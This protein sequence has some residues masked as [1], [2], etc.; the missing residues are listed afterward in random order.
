M[1]NFP[2]QASSLDKLLR[3]AR[4][5]VDLNAAGVELT[6]AAFG[7]ALAR[8]GVY[9]FREAGD[10]DV[11]LAAEQLKAP[12]NQ[13]SRTAARD[14]RRTLRLL[15]VINDDGSPTPT[16]H[17]LISAQTDELRK[18]MWRSALL[19]MGLGEGIEESHPYRILLRLV[20]DNP[21]LE[22]RKLL[23]ALEAR[24]DTEVEYDRILDLANLPFEE[25]LAQT[26]I[27]NASAANAV[28]ILPSIA[29]QL[30][31]LVRTPDAHVYP[32]G[33]NEPRDI[34]EMTAVRVVRRTT[35]RQR[36]PLGEALNPDQ[37]APAPNFLPT[38]TIISDLTAGVELRKRRTEQHQELVRRFAATLNAAGFQ[39]YA[40]LFDCLA[41]R[42][43]RAVLIEAKTLDGSP[44]DERSQSEK[45]IGQLAGYRHFD[46][47]AGVD[48]E[49]VEQV[50]LFS[51]RPTE[52]IGQFLHELGITC[53]WPT[54]NGVWHTTGPDGADALYEL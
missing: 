51:A 1:K 32:A 33:T 28:K 19:S 49:A 20:A 11:L 30:G 16:G 9:T 29:F 25:L 46:L 50:V 17:A 42:D 8:A 15:G 31:D 2:H 41:I 6:N 10:V 3:A 39:L 4:I 34:D 12:A 22:V 44:A 7:D 40:G 43:A 53:V 13:G 27:S 23:L 37:V 48:S 21:G 36:P 5:A 45:A 38:A 26:Q 14:L 47:P 54:E 24:D 35:T 52:P 18:A